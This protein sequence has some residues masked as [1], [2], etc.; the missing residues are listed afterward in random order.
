[1]NYPPGTHQGHIDER[2]GGSG[3]LC[4]ERCGRLYGSDL[5]P[6]CSAK[7]YAALVLELKSATDAG[8][9]QE[10]WKQIEEIKNAFGGHPPRI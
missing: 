10:C 4:C 7:D 9:I 6:F 8:Q 2:H 1:M 3:P 5:C